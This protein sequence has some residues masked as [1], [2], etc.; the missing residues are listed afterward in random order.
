MKR[1]ICL[2]LSLIL[3]GTTVPL[4][5]T[6][7]ASS[8]TITSVKNTK[9]GITLKWTNTKKASGYSILRSEDG[10]EFYSYDITNKKSYTDPNVETGVVYQYIVR[11]YT[12][13]KKKKKYQEAS[14]SSMQVVAVPSA[15]KSVIHHAYPDKV[16]VYWIQNQDASA[17]II[18]R[19][20][21]KIKWEAIDKVSYKESSYLDK[22]IK[23]NE[24]YF[25]KVQELRYIDGVTYYG[26]KSDIST[27]YDDPVNIYNKNKINIKTSKLHPYLQL[28]L[29]QAL[30]KCNDK[31]IYLIITEG[32]RTKKYQDSLYA[33]GR[34]KPGAIVTYARGN[35]YSSQHQWG[36][37][38]D[39]AINGPKKT[40]YNVNL[41]AKA[42]KIIKKTGLAWGGDWNGFSDMP[43]FYLKTWGATPAKLKRT[44]KK[45]SKFKKYWYRYTKK[46]TPMYATTNLKY[47][48]TV[49]KIPKG[50]KVTVY[51]YK[52]LGYS[53]V[54]YGGQSGYVYTNS[55]KKVK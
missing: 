23:S 11:P 34:T 42:A 33:Q 41:L 52:S 25:Y 22:N 16:A 1:V 38:F 31:G 5:K 21:D 24:K 36:I 14:A 44:Y 13:K 48:K 9:T 40:N 28:K 10:E 51:Y 30:K 7:A 8:V 50:S 17:Y 20:T 37:A 2:V 47:G 15:V 46:E 32:I 35:S 29:K 6:Q 18:Y 26:I 49:L 27:S 54:V 39:I 55:F 45:P 43:H 53:K 12:I 3:L 19:S 4:T